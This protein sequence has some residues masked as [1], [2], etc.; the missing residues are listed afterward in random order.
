MSINAQSISHTVC[1]N[2]QHTKRYFVSNPLD[3]ATYNWIL[4]GQGTVLNQIQDTL[5]VSWNGTPGIYSLSLTMSLDGNCI[6]DTATYFVQVLD[7]PLIT[8]AE[9]GDFCVGESVVLNASGASQIFWSNGQTGNNANFSPD[10]STTIWVLGNNGTCNSDTI[11]VNLNPVPLPTAGFLPSPT[12][13]QVPLTVNFNNISVNATTFFWEFGDGNVS[14][15]QSPEHTYTD[16]G[17]YTVK[18]TVSNNAGCSKT[19]SYSFIKVMDEFLIFFPN[20]FTP[21]GDGI[22]PTFRPIMNYDTEYTLSIYNRWGEI[23]FGQTGNNIAWDGTYKTKLAE[24]GVYVWQ[25]SLLD[26][27]IKEKRV[28]R[29]RVMLMQ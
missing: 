28:F 5:F 19:I 24:E 16:T 2:D 7:V 6:S 14:N 18:L 1:S 23:I 20:A 8:V 9:P 10:Q 3:G 27:V 4:S 25:I 12:S 22:N 26:P 17:S 29:G 21:N 13:G 11:F 15:L